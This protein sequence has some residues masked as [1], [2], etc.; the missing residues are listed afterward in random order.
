MTASVPDG[1]FV[2][3]EWM[4]ALLDNSSEDDMHEPMERHHK[5]RCHQNHM[6]AGQVFHTKSCY[7]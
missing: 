7:L 6:K 5:S 3:V 2:K 1:D 4:F